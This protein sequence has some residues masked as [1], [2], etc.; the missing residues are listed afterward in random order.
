MNEARGLYAVE[1]LA[2]VVLGL[3]LFAFSVGRFGIGGE[4]ECCGDLCR[5]TLGIP[6]P[7]RR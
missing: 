6:A 3:L 4:A 1:G 7:V 2:L 5:W